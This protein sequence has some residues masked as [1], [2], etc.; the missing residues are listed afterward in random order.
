[1]SGE[2]ILPNNFRAMINV[3]QHILFNVLLSQFEKDRTKLS[4]ESPY[5]CGSKH[6][7]CPVTSRRLTCSVPFCEAQKAARDRETCARYSILYRLRCR[8]CSTIHCLSCT[9]HWGMLMYLDVSEKGRLWWRWQI[10][11]ASWSI[12]VNSVP[13][14]TLNFHGGCRSSPV[15]WVRIRRRE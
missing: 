5:R 8:F 12:I 6:N 14:F 1:M 3:D 13:Y 9:W 7:G 10:P 15:R 11:P 4:Y 2:R